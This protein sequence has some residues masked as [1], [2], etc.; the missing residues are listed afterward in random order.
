MSAGQAYKAKYDYVELFVEQRE[1]HWLLSSAR[2]TAPRHGES[3]E[4]EDKFATS[5]E[6]QVPRFLMAQHH[7]NIQHNDTLLKCTSYPGTSTESRPCKVG[8][9]PALCLAPPVH[10]TSSHRC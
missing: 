7:I 3:V 2:G 8:L 9:R 5:G 4:S 1:G 6:T 10:K